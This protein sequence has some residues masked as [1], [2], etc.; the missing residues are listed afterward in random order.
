M[1]RIRYFADLSIRRGCGFALIAIWTAT[2]GLA[3]EPAMAVRAAAFLLSLMAAVLILFGLRAP[4]RD[5]RRTELWIL[6]DK[7]HDLPQHRAQQVIGGVLRDRYFW[8]AD[9]TLI[10]AVV[11]WTLVLVLTLGRVASTS[12]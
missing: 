3:F 4:T 5:Y 11:L 1:E 6:L 2:M 7:W 10:C 12:S 8:H 9:I